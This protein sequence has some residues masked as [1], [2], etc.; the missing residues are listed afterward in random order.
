MVG[1]VRE[2]WEVRIRPVDCQQSP[3]QAATEHSFL[4][5][6]MS[7]EG[8]GTASHISSVNAN[9]WAELGFPSL[10]LAE[11]LVPLVLFCKF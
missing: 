9:I 5:V 10:G 3:D 7:V 6:L 4:F 1:G 8:S 11:V 2:V